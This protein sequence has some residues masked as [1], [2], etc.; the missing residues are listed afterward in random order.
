MNDEPSQFSVDRQV[1]DQKNWH[2]PESQ[3]NRKNRMRKKVKSTEIRK[4]KGIRN[5]G[6]QPSWMSLERTIRDR[7]KRTSIV[8]QATRRKNKG[9]RRKTQKGEWGKEKEIKIWR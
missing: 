4:G 5:H 3:A 1:Q 6:I 2:C 7:K 9:K 8:S